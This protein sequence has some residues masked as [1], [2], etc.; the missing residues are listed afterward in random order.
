MPRSLSAI[1]FFIA[2]LS[3]VP[4]HAQTTDRSADLLA[5]G[6]KLSEQE[7]YAEAAEVFR[8][9]VAL[10]PRSFEAH[11]DLGLALFALRR[12]D[13]AR[14]AMEN[15]A[16]NDMAQNAARLYL[17][18]KIDE[19][20]GD[21]P[22]ARRE[23][24]AAF[25]TDPSEENHALD[26]GMFL[27]RQGDWQNAI[28]AFARAA[29]AHPRSTYVLLGMAMAQAFGGK[30]EDAIGTCRRIVRYDPKFSPALLVM[31]FAHYMSGEYSQ[32]ER[33][34]AAGLQLPSAA[35]YLYYLQAAALLK[36]NS[37]SYS[38]MLADLDAAERGI[39]SC[40]LCY[41][42]RSKVHEAAGDVAAAIADLN[43]LVTR[44]APDFDQAW[45]RLATLYR[46]LGQTAEAQA[47]RE[48]FETIRASRADPELELAR[49][50]LAGQERR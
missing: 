43:V 31:A 26:Y 13:E 16:P 29:E 42:V 38:Q 6:M 46:K 35:P 5:T 15:V 19:A 2:A 17:L 30:R 21:K 34:A 11:Y 14:Q 32:S 40:T 47:A 20:A 27:V 44:I 45:Y 1:P 41:F 9:C 25:K 33:A 28:Q 49:T 23:L 3:T 36:L 12:I 18:G 7:R 24:A 48:R 22:R 37:T 10:N 39:P 4:S 50:S 8:R